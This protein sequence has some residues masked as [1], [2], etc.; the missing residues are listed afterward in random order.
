MMPESSLRQRET[1]QIMRPPAI[2]WVRRRV[3]R[4]PAATRLRTSRRFRPGAR[5]RANIRRRGRA[6]RLP[7]HPALTPAEQHDRLA[8]V[9]LGRRFEAAA[10]VRLGLGADLSETDVR[11]PDGARHAVTRTV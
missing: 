1:G 9:A 5:T 8:Q 6:W 4:A 2:L 3:R 11:Q 7:R 10:E